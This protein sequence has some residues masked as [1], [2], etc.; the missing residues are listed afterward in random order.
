M[1]LSVAS[2]LAV[3]GGCSTTAARSGLEARDYAHPSLGGLK[4]ATIRT[5]VVVA[6][7]VDSGDRLDLSGFGPPQ[8]G[9]ALSARSG[10]ESAQADSL[11]LAAFVNAQLSDL[12]FA[13]CSARSSP[14]SS[15][16]SSVTSSVTPA[17]PDELGALLSTSRGCDAVL[18]VRAVP[19]DRFSIDEG[20]GMIVRQTALGRERVR[21]FR[22]VKRTGR[23]LVGQAF[24]F[25]PR[26]ATRIWSRQAPDFPEDGRLTV[27]HPF[28]ASGHVDPIGG[29]RL[30]GLE[31]SNAANRAFIAR[32]LTG[33]P[34]PRAEA[35][36]GLELPT[37]EDAKH[38][39]SREAWLDESHV[40]FDVRGGLSYDPF[41]AQL[42][43]YEKDLDLLGT[44][45]LA[46]S[47][48]FSITPTLGY[49]SAGGRL[50]SI[51]FS[52]ASV[53][54]DFSRIYHE[55]TAGP[56]DQTA[57]VRARGGSGLGLELRMAQLF[58]PGFL[59]AVAP[60]AFF[61][62]AIGVFGESWTLELTP[63]SVAPDARRFRVGA[64]GALELWLRPAQGAVFLRIGAEGRAGFDVERG[65]FLG[66]GGS[67]GAGIFL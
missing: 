65:A 3:L 12:G 46:E 18:V 34:S 20:V 27:D 45:E 23:L 15:L 9:P 25:D 50:Y 64:V 54:S 47:G 67:L 1:R 21:D 56:E 49:Q 8:L 11:A 22:P 4:L 42:S 36:P 63:E 10:G 24:L 55:D 31:L 41:G 14:S 60:S 6:P 53:R 33:F 43:W 26:T 28:L 58:G 19:V 59:S 2:L 30:T 13:A 52:W 32:I 5:Y 62:P 37:V 16:T 38:E 7:T 48:R 17:R 40:T 44:G 35:R 61:V 51:G 57:H 66:G 39:A 29:P